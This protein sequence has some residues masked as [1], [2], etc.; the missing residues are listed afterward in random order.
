VSEALNV[1]DVVELYG[2]AW[3]EHD[4]QA[5]RALLERVWAPEGVYCDPSVLVEGREALVAHISGFHERMPGHILE[6]TTDVDAH[7]AW[8]RFGWRMLDG[9]GAPVLEA[10]DVGTLGSDGRLARIV[11][12][13]DPLPTDAT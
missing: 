7:H 5:R 10:L 12:F 3:N 2:A 8:L 6:L 4:E 13:F 11:G 1:R 9:D